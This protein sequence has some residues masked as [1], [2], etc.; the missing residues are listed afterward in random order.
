M[1]LLDRKIFDLKLAAKHIKKNA[2]KLQ[3]EESKERRQCW[4]HVM[5]GH[6]DI[7]RIHAEN[8]VRNHN[9]SSKLLQTGARLEGIVNRIQT[10]NIQNQVSSAMESVVFS[11]AVATRSMNIHSI[12]QTMDKFERITEHLETR[13]AYANDTIND[14]QEIDTDQVDKLMASITDEAR[15]DLKNSLPQPENTKIVIPP[16]PLPPSNTELNEKLAKLRNNYSF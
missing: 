8:A 1:S 15:L 2:K 13:Q 9:Q 3:K 7:A 10:A 6:Q 11:M 14:S 5:R 12:A 16:L 4:L